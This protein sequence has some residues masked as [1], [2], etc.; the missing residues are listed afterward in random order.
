M[1]ATNWL[2]VESF[3]VMLPARIDESRRLLMQDVRVDAVK[4][5]LLRVQERGVRGVWFFAEAELHAIDEHQTRLRGT[6]RPNLRLTGAFLMLLPLLK[7]IVV[8]SNPA[9]LWPLSL[10]FWPL[11]LAGG[12]GVLRQKQTLKAQCLTLPQYIK[13][14]QTQAIRP[15]HAVQTPAPPIPSAAAPP[16]K[17]RSSQGA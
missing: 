12:Y 9:Q 3:S 5:G 4:N 15:G 14:A 6:I 7:I 1:S 10:V 11:L 13:A 2:P 8:M 16:L 17:A